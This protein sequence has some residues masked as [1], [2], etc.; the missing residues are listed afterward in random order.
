MEL[1]RIFESDRSALVF[2]VFGLIFIAISGFIFA[3]IYFFIDT[4]QTALEGVNCDLT[5]NAFA[6]D[7]Q[8]LFTFVLYPI[9]NY[10]SILI[11]LSYFSIFI[12]LFCFNFLLF[13]FHTII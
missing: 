11:Y 10:K 13:F 9:L 8:G 7:C 2:L 12:L 4:T 1:S 5:G 3:G 6:D